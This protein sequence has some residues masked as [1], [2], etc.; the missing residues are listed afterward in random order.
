[1]RAVLCLLLVA[2]SAAIVVPAALGGHTHVPTPSTWELNVGQSDFGGGPSVKSDKMVI[3]TD[4]DKWMKFT[5]VTVDQDGKTTKS[6]WSGAPDGTERP[7]VGIPGAKVSFNTADDSSRWTMPDGSVSE[8]TMRFA[9]GK[10]K[11]SIKVQL[12]MKDGKTYD[13]T[14]V[15]DRVK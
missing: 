5:D 8:G 7:L 6:S 12:K 10:K 15:Y 3:I 13:Q 9:D 11:I 2:A 14:L 1:M 4:T